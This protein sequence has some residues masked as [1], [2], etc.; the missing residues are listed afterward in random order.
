MN[1]LYN[2]RNW[3]RVTI[4]FVLIVSMYQDLVYAQPRKQ[5]RWVGTWAT[6]PMTPSIDEQRSFCDV[7]LR[8]IEHVSL[9]GSQI[10]IRLTNE[11]GVTPLT[12]SAAHIAL[13]ASESSIQ[14]GTDREL[15]FG[16]RTSVQIPAGS[17]IF[18]D[19]VELKVP[20]LSN[21]AVSLYFPSQYIRN[22]TIH[23]EA[24]QANY[25]AHGNVTASQAMPRAA[26]IDSWYFL[27]GVDVVASDKDA[28]AIVVLG[29]SMTEGAYSGL[30]EDHRWTDF[31]ARRL[32]GY[33]PTANLAVLNEG[34]GG[35]RILNN[36]YGPDALSRFDR[37][38]L[39]QSGVKYLIILEGTNDIGHLVKHPVAEITAEQLEIALAQM[40]G[41][42]HSAGIIVYGATMNPFGGAGY[43]SE[44][45]EE[46]REK[47]NQWI[48]TC[49]LFDGVIDFD[50]VMR[51]PKNPKQYLPEYDHGDHLHPNDSGYKAMSEAVD[52]NFFR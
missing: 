26:E 2:C 5:P 14:H 31:L 8:E 33:M 16:G 27:D 19:P 12:I 30:S 46:I 51:D 35:N 37:D 50:K 7:T 42:A 10:R 41:R 3:L 4:V 23:D 44:K 22:V 28:G 11:F 45:G 34:I 9:G 43:Y 36:G 39:S 29:D 40:A 6:S 18:S 48:R 32:Q 24:L 1:S 52:L 17:I 20:P 21:I 49:G 15:T 38:V 13:S 47:V 25:V